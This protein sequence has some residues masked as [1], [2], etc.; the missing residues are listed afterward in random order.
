SRP[1]GLRGESRRAQFMADATQAVAGALNL[2]RVVQVGAHTAVPEL[3]DWAQVAV[4]T[5]GGALMATSTG[6]RS[7][8]PVDAVGED[9]T[10]TLRRRVHT[11]DDLDALVVAD[12]ARAECQ[13]WLPAEVLSVVLRARGAP[14]GRLTVVRRDGFDDEGVAL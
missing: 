4:S 11:I 12:D 6:R 9:V 14:A 2:G 3:G 13:T 10:A 7:E 1:G 8:S 5:G